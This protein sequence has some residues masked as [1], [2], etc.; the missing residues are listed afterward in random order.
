MRA[1][2]TS[3][4]FGFVRLIDETGMREE[5]KKM[6]MSKDNVADLTAESFGYD[7]IF[8]ILEKASSRKSEQAVYEFFGNIFEME[9]NAVA[10]MDPTDFVNGIAE[11]AD[12]EKWESFFTSVAKLMKSK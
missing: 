3:D 10:D 2:K 6:V 4:V 5:L 12:R 9:P 8:M 1:L 11:I 7:V